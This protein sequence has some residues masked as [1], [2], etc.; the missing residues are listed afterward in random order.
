MKNQYF[1]FWRGNILKRGSIKVSLA[2]ALSAVLITGGFFV[3]NNVLAAH[4]TTVTLN[5]EVEYVAGNSTDTYT[6]GITND[7]PDSVYKIT[8]NI[9]SGSTF[10]I[11]TATISCPSNWT[12]DATSDNS[13]AVCITDGDPA[14]PNLL[15]SGSSENVSFS[16]SSPNNLMED[17]SF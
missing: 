16:A 11:N 17:E 6:F 12:K 14:N 1:S 9:P 2:I 5:S 4:G 8:I 3:P 7:G 15:A 13:K 10:S